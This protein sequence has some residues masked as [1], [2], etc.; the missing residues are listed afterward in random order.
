[1]LLD[2]AQLRFEI[3]DPFGRLLAVGERLTALLVELVGEDVRPLLDGLRLAHRAVRQPSEGGGADDEQYADD[4]HERPEAFVPGEVGD[5]LF[6]V[7]GGSTAS[8]VAVNPVEVRSARPSVASPIAATRIA[9][10]RI[11]FG[12]VVALGVR[13]WFDMTAERHHRP[14]AT[15]AHLN[16]SRVEAGEQ[17]SGV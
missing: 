1:M 8:A 11:T 5:T 12:D 14:T 16:A 15:R 2:G 10:R 13:V 4:R 7:G 17:W 3:E 6:R 9:A